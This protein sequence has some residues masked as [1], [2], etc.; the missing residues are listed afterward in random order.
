MFV[1][2]RKASVRSSALH[3][4]GFIQIPWALPAAPM[5]GGRPHETGQK[6]IV[7]RWNV[8]VGADLE[9]GFRKGLVGLLGNTKLS[10]EAFQITS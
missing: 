7:G 2:S 9:T 4:Y 6:V 8:A 3:T 10:G 5:D 1:I